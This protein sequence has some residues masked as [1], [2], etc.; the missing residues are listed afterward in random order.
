MSADGIVDEETPLLQGNGKKTPTPLPWSQFSI[1]LLLQLAEPLTSNVIYPFA[2]QVCQTTLIHRLLY[3]SFFFFGQLI[4][5]I[6]VTHGNESQVGYYVGIMVGV[7][8][9]T[10]KGYTR[11]RFPLAITLL[12]NPSVHSLALEQDIRSH[13][14]KTSYPLW[15]IRFV[16]VYVLFRIVENVLGACHKVSCLRAFKTLLPHNLLSRSL[17]G[18]LS[19]CPKL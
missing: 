5:D 15:P 7:E 9:R 6:G 11:N 10:L 16:A 8:P 2:P 14:S 13:W 1:A 12:P 18:A 19:K 3:E 17:N 4:R